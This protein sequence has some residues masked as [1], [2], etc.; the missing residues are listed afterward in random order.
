LGEV[1]GDT[2]G[3]ETMGD[4]RLM[5]GVVSNDFEI[6]ENV[7]PSNMAGCIGSGDDDAGDCMVGEV[8][9]LSANAVVVVG[10]IGRLSRGVVSMISASISLASSTGFAVVSS[11]LTSV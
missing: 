3:G 2:M 4:D 11:G 10:G 5:D 9:V 1:I 6:G 8:M 7:V